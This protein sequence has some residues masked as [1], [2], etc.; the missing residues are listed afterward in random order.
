MRSLQFHGACAQMLFLPTSLVMYAALVTH[1]WLDVGP[2][3]ASPDP[4]ELP[5]QVRQF[6]TAAAST[7]ATAR[8]DVCWHCLT[9]CLLISGEH[10]HLRC[11]RAWAAWRRLN[12]SVGFGRWRCSLQPCGAW[13]L[14][15]ASTQDSGRTSEH[16]ASDGCVLYCAWSG[17][18][19][20]DVCSLPS[21]AHWAGPH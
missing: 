6:R 21:P 11:V 1:H 15:A 20:C 10:L 13:P 5:A 9:A 8:T 17:L 12:A 3:A 16:G 19:E 14:G 2:F 7:L 4:Y 18:R